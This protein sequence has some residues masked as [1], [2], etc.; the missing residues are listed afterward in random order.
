GNAPDAQ[1]DLYRGR[2]R[3]L[4]R[5]GGW[6]A[7]AILGSNALFAAVEAWQMRQLTLRLMFWTGT[8]GLFALIVMWEL[9]AG[10]WLLAPSALI[11]RPGSRREKGPRLFTQASSVLVIGPYTSAVWTF[12]VSDG[13]RC[14][15]GHAVHEDIDVLLSA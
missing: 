2:W 3:R 1:T 5:H 14:K 6:L 12:A 15:T 13:R 9:S 4:R 11:H 7:V 8:L 10:Q